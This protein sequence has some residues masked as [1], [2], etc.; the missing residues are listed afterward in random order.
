[1]SEK[2]TLLSAQINP[3]VG[4]IYDNMNKII[5]IIHTYQA[6]HDVIIFPELALTGYP[7]E[8]LLLRHD[9]FIEI[10]AALTQIARA[11][12]DCHVIL[13]HPVA[14]SG[15]CFN[16]ASIFFQGQCIATYHKQRLP[17]YGVF[18]ESRYFNPG[19]TTACYFTHKNYR[20]GLCICEDVWHPGPVEQLLA[21]NVHV[22]ISIN[23][24]PFDQTKQP[25][26][27]SLI[28]NYALKG[29]N[30]IY[31]NQVGGQDELVFDGQ[32]FAYNAQGELKAR[33]PAFQECLQTIT[34]KNNQLLGEITPL[35]SKEALIYQALLCGLKD[36]VQK[37]NFNGVLLGLS[38]GIDSALTLAIAVDAM[39]PDQ[40][41]AVM[42]PSRYTANMSQEDAEHQ[43][44]ALG[45]KYTNLAI[46]PAFNMLLET[47]APSFTGY[48][49]DITEENL[50]A[51]LRCL[52]LMALSNKTGSMLLSTSNKSESAVGYTTLYGD[53]SGG[54]AV[55]KD[56][57][58]TTV[59]ALA[60]YRNSLSPV[61][62]AR[63]ITRA[64]TAELAA[65]Q[66]D[67][68]SLPEYEILDNII[69]RFMEDQL[70]A[71]EIIQ[72]GYNEQVVLKI[73]NLIKRNE[74]KRRQAP[75]GVKIT[76]CA[77]GKDWR[78]PITSGFGYDNIVERYQK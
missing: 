43:A 73:L 53:M 26:R 56:V 68:D 24:S 13:G 34:V 28:Q 30:I 76:P 54:F 29:I 35:L 19:D 67:Q 75:P 20:I 46:E 16:A 7:P 8:D 52:L 38:G 66:K 31:V 32:S 62:P 17:N 44:K 55:L 74:Y 14:K 70:S 9:L 39:G 3:K 40:V 51:R 1:M 57:L 69:T 4:S 47:L 10:E 63:V 59:Y 61:I 11:T 71:Q 45:V 50:Q 36:Y 25:L 5:D 37:N 12:T 60:N 58:K 78:Y 72:L 18:D 33:S 41:H 42:M 65:N 15:Q 64:P 77:F 48:A 49:P 22:L 2:L 21:N 27:E 23:A 6:Q